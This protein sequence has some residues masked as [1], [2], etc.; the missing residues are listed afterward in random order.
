MPLANPTESPASLQQIYQTRFA[1]KSAYRQ[2]VWAVLCPYFS[3]WIPSNATVLDLG[4]GWCEFIN[5]VSCNQKFAMDLNPDSGRFAGPEV[6][7]LQQ[8]C[9]EPWSLASDTLDVVFTSNFLEHLPTKG[10]LEKTLI[11]A[12]RALKPG[13]R[14]IALGPNVKY[15]PGA[16]WDFFDH[17][18][19]LTELSLSEALRNSGFAV[20]L[21]RAKFLPYTMSHGPQYPAWMLRLYL[22]MPVLWRLAGKQFLIVARKVS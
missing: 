7:I 22:A 5:T 8:D 21:C 19:P 6:H 15:L 18:V 16:Y 3:A 14:F 12:R 11:E 13:G 1:G 9:S 20:D 2:K 10:S 17:H 4:C